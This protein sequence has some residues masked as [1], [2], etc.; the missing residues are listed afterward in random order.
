[1]CYVLAPEAGYQGDLFLFPIREFR[2]ILAAAPVLGDKHRVYI[3]RATADQSKWYLRRQRRFDCIDSDTCLDVSAFRRAFAM[4]KDGRLK[5]HEA[6]P[7]H[8]ADPRNP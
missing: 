6:D 3:S 5:G 4:L 8:I 1:M 7:G 2:R